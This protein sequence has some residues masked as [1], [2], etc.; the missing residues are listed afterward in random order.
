MTVAEALALLGYTL[1]DVG[2]LPSLFFQLL[3]V[4]GYLCLWHGLPG[5]CMDYFSVLIKVTAKN[6]KDKKDSWLLPKVALMSQFCRSRRRELALSDK[7]SSHV[8]ISLFD[9][10]SNVVQVFTAFQSDGRTIPHADAI[11]CR[12]RLIPIGPGPLLAPCCSQ[13]LPAQGAPDTT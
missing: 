6:K 3:K 4:A 10:G 7:H 2:Y 5:M 13:V 1:Q 8:T 12:A 9:N 11:P